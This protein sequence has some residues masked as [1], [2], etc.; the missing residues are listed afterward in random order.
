MPGPVLRLADAS[1]VRFAPDDA[2]LATLG[3]ELA[4]VDARTGARVCSARPVDDPASVD[5]SP[6]G[7]RIVV[8]GTSGRIAVVDARSGRTLVDHA[9]QHEGEGVAAVFDRTGV[10]LL[11]GAWAGTIARRPADRKG[12]GTRLAFPGWMVGALSY[13]AAADRLA[14]VLVWK[15]VE[16]QPERPPELVLADGAL[17]S[18]AQRPLAFAHVVDLALAPDAS[19]CAMVAQADATRLVLVAMDSGATVAS[20]AMEL[21][22]TGAALAWSPDGALLGS[23]QDGKIV[24]YAMP[25]LRVVAEFPMRYPSS[26]A[27]APGGDTIALGGWEGGLAGGLDALRGHFGSA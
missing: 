19:L 1:A 5:F 22:G 4:V 7:A 2:S 3:R 8:K 11:D 17:A 6:D 26:V 24:V 21:G 27:F 18:H 13:A 23:V 9:N 10:H 12:A 15:Y 14:A 20:V 16:G 25:E